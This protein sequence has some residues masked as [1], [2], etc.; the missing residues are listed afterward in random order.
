[1][2][3]RLSF[4]IAINLLTEN[5]KKGASQVRASFR[6][7][8]AETLALA[9]AL[10]AGGLGLADLAS[11]FVDTAR[12]TAR[13]Q[14]ALRNVSGSTAQYADN[15][16]FVTRMAREYGLE[17]NA[18]TAQYARFAAT[19]S[20]AGMTITD[21][22]KIFESLSRATVAFGLS[23][24]QSQYVFTALSQMMSKGKIS[25]EE[26]R[27]QMGEQLPIAMQAMA[28]A[29]GT[30]V[31]GLDDLMKKGQLMSADV[32]PRFADA[33]SEMLPQVSTDN[34]EA[35]IGRL[36]NAFT[37]L[38]QSSGVQTFYKKAVE[39]V[40]SLIRQV[41][42]GLD[43]LAAFVSTLL[44]G[45]L[46]AAVAGY[47]KQISGHMQTAVKAAQL[48]EEQKQ[49]AMQKTA[50]LQARLQATQTAIEQSEGAERAKLVEQEERLKQQLQAATTRQ[51]KAEQAA[52]TAAERAAA[53]SSATAWGKAANTIKLAMA[54]VA[55]TV[56]ALI[57]SFGWTAMVAA[58]GAVVAKLVSLRQ[59]ANRIR[60]IVSD[61]RKRID[62]A[63]NTA[64][65]SMLRAQLQIMNDKTRS[66]EEINTAQQRL[67]DLLGGEKLTQQQINDRVRERIALLQEAARAEQAAREIADTEARNRELAR[68]IG[69]S[70]QQMQVLANLRADTATDPDAVKR[71]YTSFRGEDY[72]KDRSFFG[73]IK[74]Q[75]AM[76]R[77]VDEYI[78]NQKL[79][80]EATS[81]LAA[82]QQASAK[83][84]DINNTATGGTGG[85]T[86]KETE[87]EK[88][89]KAYADALRQLEA[90]RKVEA[91]TVDQYNEAYAS[92]TK[93][94]LISALSGEGTA[95]A[96]WVD[97]LAADYRSAMAAVIAATAQQAIGGM[98][99][100]LAGEAADVP[101]VQPVPMLGSRD[102]TF[103]YRKTQADIAGENLDIWQ[104]YRQQLEQAVSEGAD[105]LTGE[106]NRAIQN[107]DSLEDAL[108]LAQV[109]ADVEQLQ[110]DLR[111]GLYGGIKDVAGNADRL[112]SAF[113]NAKET[114]SNPDASGWE[115]ILSVWNAM[116]N[117][118]D[119]LMSVL[120]II[121]NMTTLTQQLAAAKQAEA[122]IDSSATATKV[123]NAATEA[124]AT[125]AA[126]QM[127]KKASADKVAA[128]TAEG[129]SE[130]GKS[131][132]KLPFPA[133]LIAIGA[134]I[135]AAL[136]AFA[137]I[138]KFARG[139]IVTGGTTAGD[140]VLARVNAGEMILNPAQQSNLFKMLN[141]GG[142][143]AG[144]AGQKGAGVTIGFDK[145]RG[146]DIYLSL[147][148]Y[149]KS[150]GKKL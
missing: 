76:Q 85:G 52:Q 118:V 130:A 23:A 53:V 82:S 50:S 93:D 143:Q 87:L 42:D 84:A 89:Q 148:N 144:G 21:Q 88:Q 75:A 43:G 63:G 73:L 115:K 80:S 14:T 81:R 94:A 145:V 77:A 91:L 66:Q 65:V 132:A 32:L 79:L 83:L 112:V 114:L 90:R 18:L 150:T 134:A 57:A 121:E 56:R 45:K 48:A 74:D 141:E 25:A 51:K 128:N 119:G 49:L 149:M 22:R 61:Y 64:E 109:Q 47:F 29:A 38:V 1:M 70:D 110:A 60:S 138:P 16:A 39:M 4:S 17:V 98:E 5:F 12:A 100:A 140:K 30:T 113:Q 44:A 136:A 19:A 129:A 96:N 146:S 68:G 31:A 105:F 102:T 123:A 78:E 67:Q 106:L 8:K 101:E 59:E 26:L 116:V 137:A 95:D 11:R 127:E 71:S 35:S 27:Q 126:S 55:K 33:L 24:E 131:A 111:E 37:Q 124:A 2:P 72:L 133:N 117:A 9:A 7:I 104:D 120:K 62:E 99:Q 41:Q 58:V 97:K 147:K 15:L 122:A 3:G 46:L 92:I 20:V 13:A 86:G 108:K 54:S 69:V 10:G 34:L 103:D 135:A 139:G 36:Q 107:V 142:G 28:K 125:L 6:A 40:T